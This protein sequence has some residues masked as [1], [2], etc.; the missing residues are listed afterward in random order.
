L[1]GAL[2]RRTITTD[3]ESTVYVFVKSNVVRAD[4]FIDLKALSEKASRELLEREEA[5]RPENKPTSRTEDA[6]DQSTIERQPE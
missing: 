6:S 2:F 5:I 1:V 4:D 3:S